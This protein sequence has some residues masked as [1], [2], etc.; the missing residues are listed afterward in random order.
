MMTGMSGSGPLGV[1]A[2]MA[3]LGQL[4]QES[5]LPAERDSGPGQCSGSGAMSWGVVFK[6]LDITSATDSGGSSREGDMVTVSVSIEDVALA[7]KIEVVLFTNHRQKA[8]D[9]G[10]GG[11]RGP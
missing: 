7:N 5:V 3:W 11:E 2:Q 1:D 6:G 9:V 10:E 4:A 8:S